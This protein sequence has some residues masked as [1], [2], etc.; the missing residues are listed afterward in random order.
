[1]YTAGEWG[2]PIGM[3]WGV[4]LLPDVPGLSPILSVITRN[5]L[6]KA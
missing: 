2:A 3:P 6:L 1:M 5:D 4:D